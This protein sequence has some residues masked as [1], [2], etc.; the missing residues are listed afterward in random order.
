ME[1]PILK[2]LGDA[3][4]R[5]KMEDGAKRLDLSGWDAPDDMTDQQPLGFTPGTGGFV[6]LGDEANSGVIVLRQN[7]PFGPIYLKPAGGEGD[8]R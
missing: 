3:G 6:S 7:Q 5:R 1:A 8:H 4:L 2:L